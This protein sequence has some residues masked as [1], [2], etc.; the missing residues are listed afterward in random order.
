MTQWFRFYESALD[1]PKVQ[2]LPADD[3]K[4]W[5]NILCVACRND[6]VLPNVSSL[7]FMLRMTEHGCRTLLERLLSAGL[8]DTRSGGPNGS[9]YAPHGWDKRQ[10]KSDTSTGRVKR[11]R[12]RSSAVAETPPD[13]DTEADT[14][15][16]KVEANAS[17]KKRASRLPDGWVPDEMFAAREGLA[18]DT[19]RREADSFRDYWRGA[20]GQRGVKADWD[21]TWRNWVRKAAQRTKP[22]VR[23]AYDYDADPANRGVL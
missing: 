23:Q 22:A 14:E 3:F 10:Y 2:T 1:D 19:I 21:A 5:V 16:G 11:F 8:I 13:T 20:P 9:H 7:A 15:K 18:A 6:G 17:T 4:A 12:D